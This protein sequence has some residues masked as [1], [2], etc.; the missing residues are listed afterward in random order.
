MIRSL[1]V[2]STA[3]MERQP[4]IVPYKAE[5]QATS[6]DD[7]CSFHL[8]ER[9]VQPNPTQVMQSAKSVTL[10]FMIAIMDTDLIHQ[11]QNPSQQLLKILCSEENVCI[12]AVGILSTGTENNWI[13]AQVLNRSGP[14][15]RSRIPKETYTD[16]KAS[17]S[18]P[19]KL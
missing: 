18:A 10:P 13:G 11:K 2:L 12:D 7:Q 9:A 6:L 4:G 5:R 17:V 8:D 14:Q 3:A 19:Q 16:F 1:Q 15:P